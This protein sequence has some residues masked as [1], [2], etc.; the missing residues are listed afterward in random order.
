MVESDVFAAELHLPKAR[1]NGADATAD[2][3]AAPA[4]PATA[5]AGKDD[6]DSHSAE[7]ELFWHDLH[8]RA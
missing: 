5:P 1:I 3:A 8:T 7:D 4:A 2:D 6:D